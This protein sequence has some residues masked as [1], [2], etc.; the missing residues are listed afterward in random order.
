MWQHSHLLLCS[1]LTQNVHR[2]VTQPYLCT[3]GLSVMVSGVVTYMGTARGRLVTGLSF[4]LEPALYRRPGLGVRQRLGVS[5]RPRH[6]WK[7]GASG[8]PTV[9]WSTCNSCALTN[10]EARAQVRSGLKYEAVAC[11]VM[12]GP[13]HID[14]WLDRILRLAARPAVAHPRAPRANPSRRRHAHS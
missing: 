1:H 11:T 4:L 14:R 10:A 5:L 9:P 2:I 7:A 3:V 6:R 8:F 12:S 13:Q